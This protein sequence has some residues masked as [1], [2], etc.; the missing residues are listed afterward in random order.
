[1]AFT[2]QFS[3]LDDMGR[4]VRR[5]F[6]NTQATIALVLTDVAVLAPL[7]DA[8]SDGGLKEVQ[9]RT[10]DDGDAFVPVAGSNIDN[11]MTLTVLGGNSNNYAMKIPM[12]IAAL[13]LS[14][15]VV[16]TSNAALLLFLAEF[17]VG[18]N[19]RVNLD[20]PQDV[21]SITKG[22]IDK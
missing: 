12:P 7:W 21:V 14:G 13:K 16:D 4:L 9:I 2:V 5:S 3:L 19:W 18:K 8:I 17:A 1:M 11:G 10:K 15:G 22:V 6:H 20:N